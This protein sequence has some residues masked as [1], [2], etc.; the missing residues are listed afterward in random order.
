MKMLKWS[1]L[2]V[3][4]VVV[5]GLVSGTTSKVKAMDNSDETVMTDDQSSPDT[6][7]YV[8]DDNAEEDNYAGS[9]EMY[10]EGDS[11]QAPSDDIKEEHESGDMNE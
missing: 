8:E 10:D 4:L 1:L 11:V 9:E 7:A 2:V 6:G 3:V 5:M